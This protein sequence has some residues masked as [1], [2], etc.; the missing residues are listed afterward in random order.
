MDKNFGFRDSTKKMRNLKPSALTYFLE[1]AHKMDI[2]SCT[3][4]KT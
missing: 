1:I 2:Y 4:H 3:V